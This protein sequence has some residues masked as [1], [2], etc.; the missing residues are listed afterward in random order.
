[1]RRS[2]PKFEGKLVIRK[3]DTVKVLAGKD[4]GKTGTVLRVFPK[5]GKILVEGVN[6]ATKHQKAQPTPA[7]P[8]P[9]GGRVEIAVP[10][11]VGKVALVNS[12]GEPTRVRV[13][14]GSDGKKVRIAVKGGDTV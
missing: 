12:Q 10:M 8:N 3:G 5:T 13:G 6:I 1:M 11:P 14:T 9:T 7:D 2:A 4:A